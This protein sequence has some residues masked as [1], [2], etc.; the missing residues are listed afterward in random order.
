MP[1]EH[2]QASRRIQRGILLSSRD[3]LH[4]RDPSV[5][6]EAVGEAVISIPRVEIP[7]PNETR[8]R[9][10]PRRGVRTPMP[11]RKKKEVRATAESTREA[12]A[13]HGF[14]RT[15]VVSIFLLFP[16]R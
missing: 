10:T 2:P 8:R 9:N 4:D 3:N 11:R 5:G 6:V 7:R 15:T 14:K 1:T 16:F 12:I 13:H